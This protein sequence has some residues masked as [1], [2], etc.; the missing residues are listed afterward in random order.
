MATNGQVALADQ[1]RRMIA[2]TKVLLND[3]LKRVLREE[4]MPVSGVKA[5][6]QLR[7]INCKT[8][9]AFYSSRQ[10][11]SPTPANIS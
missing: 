2:Q 7:I 9:R 11:L 6:L 10:I 1:V 4:Q 8:L 5:E 3:Q